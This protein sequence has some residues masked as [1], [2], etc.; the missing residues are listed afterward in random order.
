MR[1]AVVSCAQ[2]ITS[3]HLYER[4]VASVADALGWGIPTRRCES[5][6]QF[7]VELQ[8]LVEMANPLCRQTGGIGNGTEF[9]GAQINH[10]LVLVLDRVDRQREAPVTLLPGLARLPEMV[11]MHPNPASFDNSYHTLYHINLRFSP[12]DTVS[13]H[14]LYR[15]IAV[16]FY[17]PHRRRTACSLPR[18]H[19]ARIQPHHGRHHHATT[20]ITSVHI[21]AILTITT[22]RPPCS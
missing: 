1:H 20:N 4:A 3:R 12:P 21:L 14:D 11:S 19:Q 18:L 13:D 22:Q 16:P 15:Y 8:R 2:C 9:D 17:A 5:L 6:A 10:R 7:L